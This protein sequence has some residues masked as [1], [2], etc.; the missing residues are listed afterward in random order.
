MKKIIAIL[1]A[2][3]LFALP[4]FA[5]T[6][7]M[8]DDFESDAYVVG[9]KLPQYASFNGK[10]FVNRYGTASYTYGQ[11]DEGKTLDVTLE[12]KSSLG[13]YCIFTN[14]DPAYTQYLTRGV[15][16][17]AEVK[18]ADSMSLKSSVRSVV[19]KSGKNLFVIEKNMLSVYNN[20]A[21]VN[22]DSHKAEFTPDVFHK[23]KIIFNVPAGEFSFWLDGV[24][25]GGTNKIN[26]D[27]D[28]SQ[29][30]YYLFLTHGAPYAKVLPA[31]ASY[32][33]FS[34]AGYQ[35]ET[36]EISSKIG[37][38]QNDAEVS[39][40]TPGEEEQSVTFDIFNN[41][42]SAAKPLVACFNY[43]VNADGF[44]YVKGLKF[45]KLNL[46]KGYNKVTMD[47]LFIPED[48]ESYSKLF[49]LDSIYSP[50]V[51]GNIYTL[52]NIDGAVS[53]VK[54]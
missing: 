53:P 15:I 21:A 29:G 4:C 7:I 32:N 36:V 54:E 16:L 8:N 12:S 22:E 17:E 23:I 2:A 40:F 51:F 10:T 24:N 35:E 11:S 34:I 3:V 18:L 26:E 19:N 39:S 50:T 1:M 49:F 27:F 31:V 33:S 46:S 14:A 13:Y 37:L 28:W 43:G 38:S 9:E 48:G 45:M 25:I 52:R 47:G 42:G 41:K 6:F 5:E 44:S 20:G 30:M